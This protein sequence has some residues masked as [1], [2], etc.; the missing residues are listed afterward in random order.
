MSTPS[1]LIL[2]LDVGTTAAKASIFALDRSISFTASRGYPLVSPQ[3]GQHVQDPKQIAEGVFE[4]MREAIEQVDASRIVGISI[5]TAMHGLM[6]LDADHNPV[7]DLITWADSRASEEAHAISMGAAGDR[8]HRISGT[9]VH[10]MSPLVKLRWF[11]RNEP[12]LLNR[13]KYWIGLKDWI[14]VILTDQVVTELSNASGTGMADL[15]ERAWNPEALEISGVRDDQLPP[16]LDTTD[17]LPLS[18]TAANALGLTEGLPVVVGAGDGPLGNLGTGALATGIAG[19]SIG[20]SGALRMVTKIPAVAPG[21]FCYA[22]TRD[23]WVTGGAISNGG[24]VQR[25]LTETFAPG[26]D[27]AEACSRAELIP[28]GSDGLRM[29]PYLVSERA[30]LWDPGI[31]GAFLHVRRPHTPDHFVRAGVEGVAL[32]LWTILRRLRTLARVTQVRAT[33]GVFRSP[34]WRDVAAGVLNRPLVITGAEEGSGLGAA[35]LGMYAL[36]HVESLQDGYEQLRDPAPDI[37]VDVS[38]EAQEA[39][40]HLRHSMSPLLERYGKLSPQYAMA[41]TMSLAP[42]L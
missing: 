1:P 13:T 10:A 2:G 29:I 21:L 34:L 12:G 4:A 28:P 24:M 11:A 42:G 37:V 7:T 15:A 36:G 26:C 19:L 20:T 23:L 41:S 25:W 9:P 5:S 35:V 6:G 8:L 32:Q 31:R 39:Y 16:I 3:A 33:G 27:D 14:L 40:E 18:S 22:L 17:T 30:S 38:D